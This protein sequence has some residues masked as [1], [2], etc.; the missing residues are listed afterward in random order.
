VTGTIA[1]KEIKVPYQCEI[2][3]CPLDFSAN[4]LEFPVMQLDERY[5]TMISVK[6]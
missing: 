1:T 6:N 2:L 5:S 3:R 4:K